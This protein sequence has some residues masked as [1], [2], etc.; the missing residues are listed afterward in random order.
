MCIGSYQLNLDALLARIVYRWRFQASTILLLLATLIGFGS[1]VIPPFWRGRASLAITAAPDA[2]VQIDGRSWPRPVYAGWHSVVAALP[3]GRRSRADIELQAG[4]ALALTLPAGL[5]EPRERA[6]PPA[7]P[8]T[9]IDQVWWADGGWRVASVADAPPA[10]QGKDRYDADATPTPQPGQTIAITRS[11]VERLSTLDAYD[12]LADRVHVDGQLREAVY[13][14][15]VDRGFSDSALGAIEVRG[16]GQA[17]QTFPISAPLSLLRFAPSGAA[18]LAAEQVPS[19]GEQVSLLRPGQPRAAL[20][21]VPGR[22]VRLSWRP[23]STAVVIHSVQGERLTLTL[24]RLTPSIAA[25]VV[26]VSPL[27]TMPVALFR[28]HGAMA[29]CYGSRRMRRAPQRF[30]ALRSPRSSQSGADLSML[31][32]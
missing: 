8:G 10:S 19:G 25:A 2:T 29:D 4:E 1:G 17:A 15:K 11:N 32:H 16:W 26:T 27:P 22:I 14:P 18:L 21:A 23:D 31:A 3:D 9:H 24:V 5:P 7:A 6:L 30:G 28:S 13:Q 20:V 12:G